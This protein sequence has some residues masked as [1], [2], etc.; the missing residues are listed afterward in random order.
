M[1]NIKILILVSSFIFIFSCQGAKDAIQ[2]KKRSQSS[3]EFLVEKKNPLIMPPDI[4]ELPVP[5]DKEEASEDS[6]KNQI[7]ELI[8]NT[9]DS[10][11][12]SESDNNKSI[13]KSILEKIKN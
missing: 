10:S 7:K 3:D 6:K 8:T 5:L 1:K 11:E 9:E 4:E 12:S 2:G 13:E